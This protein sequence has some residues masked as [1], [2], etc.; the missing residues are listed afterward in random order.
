MAT[1]AE[2][3]AQARKDALYN[4]YMSRQGTALSDAYNQQVSAAQAS[5]QNNL[6]QLT[7]AANTY[8]ENY[9]DDARAAYINKMQNDQLVNNELNRLGLQ[10]SGYGVTQRLSTEANYGENLTGLQKNLATNLTNID[11]QK[12]TANVGLQQTLADLAS[13][14]AN[15]KTSENQWLTNYL[16]SAYND[17]YDRAYQ[18]EQDKLALAAS[19]SRG[20]GGSSGGGSGSSSN[21]ITTAY[22]SGKI[23]S[24]TANAANTYGTFSNGYQPKGIIG[25]GT[26]DKTGETKMVKSTTINGTKTETKQHVW[27]TADGTLWIW[28]G[29]AMKYEKI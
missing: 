12:S 11:M 4:E 1:T 2:L 16:Q 27:K 25:Y 18:E 19:Y 3:A 5:T 10:N 23:P 17:A 29:M 24:A 7:Q 21:S 15:A 14:Y 26:V 13:N 6:D 8:Q 20:G 9:Q 22:Y 28:N